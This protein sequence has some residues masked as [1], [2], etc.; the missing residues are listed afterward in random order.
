MEKCVCNIV[1][2]LEICAN[3]YANLEKAIIGSVRAKS[4]RKERV[5][6]F[7]IVFIIVF[8][9]VCIASYFG[10][11]FVV[12]LTVPLVFDTYETVGNFTGS[13]SCRS[14]VPRLRQF[15]S[16]LSHFAHGARRFRILTLTT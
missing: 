16:I 5:F 11:S 7:L 3:K 1:R 9:V 10:L 4:S 15:L 8:R 13:R 2:F 12:S 14:S 6:V